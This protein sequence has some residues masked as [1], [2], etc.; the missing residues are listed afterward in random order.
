MY[1]IRTPD[2]YIDVIEN[3]AVASVGKDAEHAKWARNNLR[4]MRKAF[5][6]AYPERNYH[7]FLYVM[8]IHIATGNVLEP[9]LYRADNEIDEVMRMHIADIIEGNEMTESEVRATYA[10]KVV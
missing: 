4:M 6:R 1:T 7:N 10:F 5:A 3:L 9:Q 2:E 8:T